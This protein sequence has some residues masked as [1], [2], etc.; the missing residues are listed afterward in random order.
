[1]FVN[2][3]YA[4][5]VI[6]IMY[7][8]HQTLFISRCSTSREGQKQYFATKNET[9]FT[10]TTKKPT[11]QIVMVIYFYSVYNLL[12]FAHDSDRMELKKENPKV[13]I[14]PVFALL[15]CPISS[16]FV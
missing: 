7:L 10:P 8:N 16:R 4:S 12:A 1:M 6:M 13:S 9:D 15:L 5:N 3:Y 14:L 2:K 11:V